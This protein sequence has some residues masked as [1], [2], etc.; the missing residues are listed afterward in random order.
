MKLL[1]STACLLAVGFRSRLR[2][3]TRFSAQHYRRHGG[4]LS[5]RIQILPGRRIVSIRAGSGHRGLRVLPWARSSTSKRL[6]WARFPYPTANWNATYCRRP[7]P[8]SSLPHYAIWVSKGTNVIYMI[9]GAGFY[10]A[11]ED[12]TLKHAVLREALTKKYGPASR[13][14]TDFWDAGR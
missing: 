11:E 3:R 2:R 6:L 12:A 5:A 13:Q 1:L 9:A 10:D 4:I 14:E 8:S 7:S